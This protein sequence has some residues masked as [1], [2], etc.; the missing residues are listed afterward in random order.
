VEYFL[1]GTEPT[2]TCPGWSEPWSADGKPNL[3]ERIFDT[4]LDRL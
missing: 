1:P 2:T 3:M 4:W